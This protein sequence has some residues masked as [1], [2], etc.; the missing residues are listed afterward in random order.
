MSGKL[1]FLLGI[2]EAGRGP[3][4]GPVSV[5]AVL[6][7]R[8]YVSRF[9]S[10]RDSKKTTPRERE[11]I[12]NSLRGAKKDGIINYAVS[13]VGA[14]M[15][16]RYGISKAVRVAIR[17]TTKKL[18]IDGSKTEILLD[19]LLSAP[20]AYKF[21]KT[22]KG[23]DQKVPIIALASIAAKVV[24]DRKMVRLSKIFPQ[25]CFHKHKG[26]GTFLHRSLLKEH[27]LSYIH[28]KSYC[29]NLL[30]KPSVSIG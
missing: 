29:K 26:Y 1:P 5:G 14:R 9:Q 19:G 27:G 21:Q 20:K 25:Y 6:I 10:L 22:I 7:P 2:D 16:D 17:R 23:G 8:R 11:E 28:R 15:I 12:F 30:T 3:L 4:A 18:G 24:R 13:C